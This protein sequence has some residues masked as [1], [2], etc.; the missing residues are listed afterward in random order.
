MKR[1]IRHKTTGMVFADGQWHHDLD[2]AQQFDSLATAVQA[3]V[4]YHLAGAEVI[5]QMGEQPSEHYDIRL[6]LLEHGLGPETQPG[7]RPQP[8]G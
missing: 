2:Q 7:Q 4:K 6:D 5:L 8:E 3:A 1:F